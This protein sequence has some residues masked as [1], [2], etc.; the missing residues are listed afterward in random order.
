MGGVCVCGRGGGRRERE[1]V[2]GVCAVWGGGGL[3][4]GGV[5]CVGGEGRGRR[6]GGEGG[7][8][9]GEG[10]DGEEGEE[11][12]GWER[13]TNS[14]TFENFWADFKLLNVH[15]FF[16]FFVGSVPFGAISK[17]ITYF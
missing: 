11:G 12:R 14:C 13:S 1:C 8:G 15:V 2:C 3:G 6:D 10:E 7:G 4:W 16:V 17:A 9:R 5:V